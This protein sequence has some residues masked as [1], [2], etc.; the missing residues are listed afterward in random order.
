MERCLISHFIQSANSHICIFVLRLCSNKTT[1]NTTGDALTTNQTSANN[2]ITSKQLNSGYS[3]TTI[4]NDKS[5]NAVEF[6][7]AVREIEALIAN[8]L[9]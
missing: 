6:L 5:F 2:V 7:K 9:I 3:N 8:I 4:I 1:Q